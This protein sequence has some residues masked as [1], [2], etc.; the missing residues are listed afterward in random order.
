MKIDLGCGA[1][2]EPGYTGIDKF[3][4][5]D[6]YP[7]GDFIQG[8]IPEI[9]NEFNDNSIDEVRANHF[10]EHIPQPKVIPFMNEVY[11]ILKVGGLF[12]IV[13]PPT[14]SKGAWCDPTH[15]SF[16]NEDSFM[17]YNLDWRPDLSESYGIKCDFEQLNSETTERNN[18]RVILKKK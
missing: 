6:K 11:R 3:D 12:R 7:D 1:Y 16:W 18:L 17:Y 4:W 13:V 15:V 8:D 2:K 9:L 5:S 10:I 14:P